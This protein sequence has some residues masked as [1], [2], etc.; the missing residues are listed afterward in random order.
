MT[1]IQRFNDNHVLWRDGFNVNEDRFLDFFSLKISN[2][3]E[4]HST[5]PYSY[6]RR[7]FYHH[8]HWSLNHYQPSS[9]NSKASNQVNLLLNLLLPSSSNHDNERSRAKAFSFPH[10]YHLR[11]LSYFW[12][13]WLVWSQLWIPFVDL[14]LVIRYL[15]IAVISM[16]ETRINNVKRPNWEIL[17]T[18]VRKFKCRSEIVCT[19]NSYPGNKQAQK[20]LHRSAEADGVNNTIL[21]N[22][23]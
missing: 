9:N 10:H 17:Q 14:S 11:I 7:F 6:T 3:L 23:T 20:E 5:L 13:D 4:W 22:T 1:T 12:L 15:Y 8:S 21:H 18:Q 19:K 2:E 16:F